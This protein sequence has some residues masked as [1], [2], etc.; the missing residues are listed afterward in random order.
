M[1]DRAKA[2]KE[3]K[4]QKSSKKIKFGNK[5]DSV[6][7]LAFDINNCRGCGENYFETK[8]KKTG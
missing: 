8:K 2:E 3:L 6:H 5:C 1:S 7:E 4:Q